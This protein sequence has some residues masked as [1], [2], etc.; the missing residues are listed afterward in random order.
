MQV[1]AKTTVKSQIESVSVFY[2]RALLAKT[3]TQIR[4]RTMI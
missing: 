1:V 4:K 2:V 3:N